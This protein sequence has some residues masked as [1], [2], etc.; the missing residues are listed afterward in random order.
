[1][2]VEEFC[3]MSSSVSLEKFISS[4][5]LLILGYQHIIKIEFFLGLF[6]HVVCFRLG[7]LGQNF[8]NF[9]LE[10]F[11]FKRAREQYCFQ[12]FANLELNASFFKHLA[13]FNLSLHLDQ[14]LVQ[15][16]ALR[17][18]AVS[19][20]FQIFLVALAS[21]LWTAVRRSLFENVIR[22]NFQDSHCFVNVL[23]VACSLLPTLI[24]LVT[25]CFVL[26]LKDL[27][28]LELSS[29]FCNSLLERGQLLKDVLFF[30]LSLLHSQ[31][32]AVQAESVATLTFLVFRLTPYWCYSRGIIKRVVCT[33]GHLTLYFL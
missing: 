22:V 16:I 23:L 17:T 12:F 13:E 3:E 26:N 10:F 30:F 33:R 28:L 7:L 32:M 29:K 14:A 21:F 25:W 8:F 4:S 5:C 31:D 11:K 20:F 9:F 27:C 2:F 24:A 1:M 6:S 18:K 19:G 15:T